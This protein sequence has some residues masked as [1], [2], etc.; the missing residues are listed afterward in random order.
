M[1]VAELIEILKTHPQDLPVTSYHGGE[2]TGFVTARGVR[3]EDD[4]YG[5]WDDVKGKR[6]KGPR[7]DI[8]G[9]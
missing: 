1:T 4:E 9:F 7:I 8:M 2:E 3:L 5:V 6:V